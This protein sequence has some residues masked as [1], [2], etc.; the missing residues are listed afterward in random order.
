MTDLGKSSSL[1]ILNKTN[2]DASVKLVPVAELKKVREQLKKAEK[3]YD[4]QALEGGINVGLGDVELGVKAG[5]EKETGQEQEKE[6]EVEIEFGFFRLAEDWQLL[7][8]GAETTLDTYTPCCISI[9]IDGSK[10]Q[11]VNRMIHPDRLRD[12][13]GIVFVK[14]NPPFQPHNKYFRLQKNTE[15]PPFRLHNLSTRSV[16][17]AV[18]GVGLG[19]E[20]SV[21]MKPKVPTKSGQPSDPS[22]LWMAHEDDLCDRQTF[23]LRPVAFPHLTLRVNKKSLGLVLDHPTIGRDPAD[24]KGEAKYEQWEKT[25]SR[26]GPEAEPFSLCQFLSACC[27]PPVPKQEVLVGRRGSADYGGPLTLSCVGL[28]EHLMCAAEDM[29]V[30]KEHEKRT[31]HVWQASVPIVVK[32]ETVPIDRKGAAQD[33][34]TTASKEKTIFDVCAEG[35]LKELINFITKEPKCLEEADDDGITPLHYSAQNGR[36]EVIKEIVERG[37]KH[38]I[39]KRTNV[40]SEPTPIHLAAK[41]GH[42]SV[43]N[44]LLD[45]R[46]EHL[47]KIKDKYGRTIASVAAEEGQLAVLKAIVNRKS[48]GFILSLE[49]SGRTIFHDAALG[50]DIGVLQ[51]LMKWSGSRDVLKL[52]NTP[53][54]MAGMQGHREAV[55]CMVN[56][57]G[58]RELLK[59]TNKHGKTPID[60]AKWRGHEDLATELERMV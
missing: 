28:P 42:V 38:L 10:H 24:A 35:D 57:Q 48:V 45:L 60:L 49:S 43:V 9:F 4:R 20:A 27:K 5:R 7:D 34:E 36:K 50:G 6:M 22:Q 12:E 58:G 16:L 54:H 59:K 14:A 40:Q 26:E 53:M 37:G 39:E 11:V 3:K 8:A 18:P 19:E 41:R 30:M 55:I 2:L 1:R 25:E 23:L 15:A 44:L 13:N 56:K 32:G 47:L 29:L 33:T 21:V 17:T 31:A 46:G 52:G 51:Q